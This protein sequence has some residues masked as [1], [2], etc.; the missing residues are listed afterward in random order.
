VA[1]HT[2]LQSAAFAPNANMSSMNAANR[3]VTIAPGL[4]LILFLIIVVLIGCTWI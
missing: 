3:R 2:A 4:S 1:A